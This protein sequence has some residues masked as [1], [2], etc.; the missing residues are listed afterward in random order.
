MVGYEEVKQYEDDL[1]SQSL[2]KN[3]LGEEDRV[4]GD[5]E[6]TVVGRSEPKQDHLYRDQRFFSRRLAVFLVTLLSILLA[7]TLVVLAWLVSFPKTLHSDR[8][9]YITSEHNTS[10]VQ[11]S[12]GI[13]SCGRTAREAIAAGCHFDTF[14]FGWTPPECTDLQLYNENVALLFNQTGGAFAFYTPNHDPIPFSALTEYGTGT[15]PPGAAVTDHHEIFTTW[16]HYLVACAY[17]WQKL[18]RAAMRNWPLEEWSSS[19]ALARQCGPDMLTRERRESE[20]IMSHLKPWYPICGL[21]VEQ[22]RLEIEAIP[23]D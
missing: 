10:H 7:S 11:Q 19:Y 6:S 8:A 16:E 12:A 3:D 4:S 1:Q 2:L 15:S 14:S 5:G 22:T 13:T 21:E 20:S 23:Q 9:T 17:G 18:Q